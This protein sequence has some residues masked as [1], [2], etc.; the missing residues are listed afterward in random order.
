M[1]ELNI[2]GKAATARVDGD[3]PFS[4]SSATTSA[5][6]AR[7]TVAVSPSAAPARCISTALRCA[8]A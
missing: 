2:N 4:G 8:P 5:S 1:A 3:T 6:L 7:S